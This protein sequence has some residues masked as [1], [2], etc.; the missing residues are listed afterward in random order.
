MVSYTKGGETGPLR[1]PQ[2]IMPYA[3]RILASFCAVLW[4][5]ALVAQDDPNRQLTPKELYM[6]SRQLPYHATDEG[7]TE[8]KKSDKDGKESG[9]HG[10]SGTG[11]KPAAPAI[12][13]RYWILKRVDGKMV[14]V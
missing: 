12:G 5:S 2:P 9:G 8:G 13:V 4:I 10:K 1:D 14:E 6:R 11:V 7:K 3:L